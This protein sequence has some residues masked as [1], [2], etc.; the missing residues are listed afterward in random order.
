MP[1]LP[2]PERLKSREAAVEPAPLLTSAERPGTASPGPE[3]E[4]EK[5]TDRFG[6]FLN[7]LFDAA[8][9]AR[10]Q[11]FVSLETRIGAVVR[12]SRAVRSLARALGLAK[13]VLKDDS[14]EWEEP[15]CDLC[16]GEY[17]Y[18]DLFH[19][20]LEKKFAALWPFEGR[21]NA[22]FQLILHRWLLD[23]LDARKRRAKVFKPPALA[24]TGTDEEDDLENGPDVPIST[25]NIS[26]HDA[27]WRGEGERALEARRKSELAEKAVRGVL[28]AIPDLPL[29][30][31]CLLK[32]TLRQTLDDEECEFLLRKSGHSSIVD[33]Q[34]ELAEIY[35]DPQ[36][37]PDENLP[38]NGLV[39]LFNE[40]RNTLDVWLK[41]AREKLAA[42]VRAKAPEIQEYFAL[43]PEATRRTGRRRGPSNRRRDK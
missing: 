39:R 43:R 12:Y 2:Y 11:D 33:L 21:Y 17:C 41:R 9:E 27:L 32:V 7:A 31:R 20:A 29:Q 15:R 1:E 18:Q 37:E 10:R 3:T 6:L 26:E 30:H 13:H 14:G 16:W 24:E 8:A 22:W 19:E 4:S 35:A 36:F 34:M 40:R 42:A 23:Q 38:I 28:D 5:G 25:R